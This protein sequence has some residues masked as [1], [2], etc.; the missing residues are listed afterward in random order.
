MS[1]ADRLP[2]AEELVLSVRSEGLRCAVASASRNAPLLLE[3]VGL[4]P[5]FDFVADPGAVAR[6]KPAPDIFLACSKALGVPPRTC[7]AFEDAAAGIK[8]I[9][10]AGM[11]AVGIGDP[12]IL[13]GADLTFPDTAAVDLNAIRRVWPASRLAKDEPRR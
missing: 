4:A 13:T 6:G 1:P 2:G 11:F 3:R 10:A 12:A 9:V 7:M 8:A 5:L